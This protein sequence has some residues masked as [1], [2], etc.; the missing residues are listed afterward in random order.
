MAT[1]ISS[2]RQ[3]TAN[4]PAALGHV[5]RESD[6][7]R[8]S[9]EYLSAIRSI[10]SVDD[11]I[12]NDRVYRYALQAF[13]LEDLAYGKAFI[14]KV[15]SEGIDRGDSLANRL[16]DP[17]FRELAQ[18]FNFPR[19]G[20]ATVSFA[21]TQQGTV[22]RFVRQVLETRAGKTNEGVRLALYFQRKA[23]TISSAY[24]LL[25]DRALLKVTQVV[26]GLPESTGALAIDRQADLITRRLD[27]AE[28]SRPESLDKL[29]KRFAALWD[30]ERPTVPSSIAD[31]AASPR[32][33]AL[34][35]ELI[36]RI[37]KSQSGG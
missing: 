30:L 27:I 28:L 23:P 35:L 12:A 5:A 10:K 7:K 1:T 17:R 11:F 14:R 34:G 20:A 32:P 22:D 18:A 24:S 6:V 31:F 8:R 37:Q 26:L 15:L 16:A 36:A 19:Y 25:A 13:G 3:L 29:M 33:A 4:L 21:R 9:D 2:L